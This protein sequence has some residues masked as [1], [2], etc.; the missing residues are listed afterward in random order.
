[1]RDR[2][3]INGSPPAWFAFVDDVGVT[4]LRGAPADD[5]AFADIVLDARKRLDELEV[6]SDEQLQDIPEPIAL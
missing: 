5:P 6:V 4:V 2:E 1:M 3:I